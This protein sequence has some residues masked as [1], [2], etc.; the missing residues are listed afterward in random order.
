M[1]CYWGASC[2]ECDIIS[3]ITAQHLLVWNHVWLVL[4][5]ISLC[6]LFHALQVCY[7]VPPC[8]VWGAETM[9]WSTTGTH[10]L[11]H[12]YL[13]YIISAQSRSIWCLSCEDRKIRSEQIVVAVCLRCSVAT[14]ANFSSSVLIAHMWNVIASHSGSLR[15]HSFSNTNL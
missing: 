5:K 1:S 4:P 10:M 3:Y 8:H 7:Q 6:V 9:F 11:L 13:S 15:N 14:E 2:S 12:E